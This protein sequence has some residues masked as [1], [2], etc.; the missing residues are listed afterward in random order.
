MQAAQHYLSMSAQVTGTLHLAALASKESCGG[1]LMSHAD[2]SLSLAVAA[3]GTNFTTFKICKIRLRN[4]RSAT[5]MGLTAPHCSGTMR[6]KRWRMRAV[7]SASTAE[8]GHAA[9]LWSTMR[10]GGSAREDN[11]YVDR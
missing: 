5:A 8:Y 11:A 7:S 9:N 6:H 2:A 10:A 1:L 3:L 4:A